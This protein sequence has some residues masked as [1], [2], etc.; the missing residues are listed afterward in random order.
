MS[1]ISAAVLF[2]KTG[3]TSLDAGGLTEN[4]VMQQMVAR[5][6]EPRCW[7]SGNTARL[8]L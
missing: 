8:I 3:R 7:T 1:G 6:I 2:D 5:G 4:Y